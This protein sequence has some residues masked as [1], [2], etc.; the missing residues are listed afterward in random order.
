MKSFVYDQV[1]VG[2]SIGPIEYVITEDKAQEHHEAIE[3]THPRFVDGDSDLVEPSI[4]ASAEYAAFDAEYPGPNVG[5]HTDHT[6][7]FYAPVRVGMKLHVEGEVTDKYEKRERKYVDSQV[8]F[9]DEDGEPV[10]RAIRSA[11]RDRIE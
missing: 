8:D 5:I 3:A 4:L 7:E 11:I 2:E 1:E 10:G 9:E 6:F